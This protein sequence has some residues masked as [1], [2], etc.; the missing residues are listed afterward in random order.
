MYRMVPELNKRLVARLPTAI[1]CTCFVSASDNQRVGP[2]LVTLDDLMMLVLLY[3]ARGTN[4]VTSSSK[5]LK[6]FSSS[7]CHQV[8]V[9][10]SW[11]IVGSVSIL[12]KQVFLEYL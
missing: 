10:V 5:T 6:E 7:C 8:A 12:L 4:V 3:D 2:G 9:V 1:A 11:F